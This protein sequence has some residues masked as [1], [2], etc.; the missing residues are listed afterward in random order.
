MVCWLCANYSHPEARM[1][2]E[3]ILERVHAVEPE[4]MAVSITRHLGSVL[5]DADIPPITEA[6]V[7]LHIQRHVMHPQV[8]M[9]NMLRNLT[10]LSENLRE[11]ICTRGEDNTP[12]VDVRAASLY[13]KVVSEVMQV[14]RNTD[15]SKLLFGAGTT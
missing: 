10:D 7:L 5:M 15:P 14:Y 8:R 13:I 3:F 12:L 9:A 11:V 4:A 6:D 2:Q 1:V